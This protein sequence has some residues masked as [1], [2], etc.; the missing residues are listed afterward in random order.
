MHAEIIQLNLR[1]CARTN[2]TNLHQILLYLQYINLLQ[3]IETG[4]YCIKPAY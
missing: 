1:K 2:V 3:E 4:I